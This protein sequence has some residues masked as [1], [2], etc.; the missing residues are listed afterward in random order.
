M[1]VRRTAAFLVTTDGSW[2]LSK[3]RG[4]AKLSQRYANSLKIRSETAAAT[5]NSCTSTSRT[6]I[7]LRGDGT[8]ARAA[9]LHPAP[10]SNSERLFAPGLMP[11]QPARRS[12]DTRKSIGPSFISQCATVGIRRPKLNPN[13]LRDRQLADVGSCL[14]D[15]FDADVGSLRSVYNRQGAQSSATIIPTHTR[16]RSDRLVLASRL[17]QVLTASYGKT[18]KY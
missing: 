16:R 11:A 3:W 17:L 10:R 1:N 5:L 2:P 15:Y 6:T 13:P 12:K 8:P 9:I 7:S 4:R 18:W 14:G